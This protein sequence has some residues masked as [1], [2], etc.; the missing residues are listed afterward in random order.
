MPIR[1]AERAKVDDRGFQLHRHWSVQRD[2]TRVRVSREM[3]RHDSGSSGPG[4]YLQIYP[5]SLVNASRMMKIATAM[6]TAIDF[7][8]THLVGVASRD[9][10]QHEEL[11]AGVHVVRVNGSDRLGNIG[12]VLRL[13]FW[14][15]Q[16]YRHYRHSNVSVVAAHIV[17]VLPLCWLL[18]R[19]TGAALVYNAHELETETFTMRGLKQKVA[20]AI[21]SRLI[22]SCRLVSV[23]NSS[24]ADWY[25]AEYDIERPIVVGN[26]PVDRPTDVRMRERLGV[27]ASAMLYSHTGHLVGGRSIPLILASF[28]TS[29]HHVVFLGDG[30]YR[31][32]V[33]A[34]S[35]AHSNIHWLAPV[36][37]ELIVSHVREADV[38]LCLIECQLD[39][40]DRLS[41]PNKLL[42]SL[43]AGV[44]ALCSDLIEARK[45]LGLL[46]DDW[47][48]ANPSQELTS[49][50]ARITK[51]D[52]QKFR[53]S[54][55]GTTTWA[56]EV[57]P[58][59]R[60]Y[61]RLALAEAR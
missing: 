46:A 23:V 52:V 25:E 41:S 32:Q 54:W 34:A 33:V 30:P 19:K 47:L 6:H 21:E 57:A 58:L 56:D 8:E 1:D 51:S 26:V 59:A 53:D 3:P 10:Q 9:C 61:K 60:S 20:K 22:Q 18:S 44:P 29:D 11:S 15:P 12:R 13:L 42:E 50:L 49:A 39:L 36:D 4:L 43:A 5:S 31:E 28:A 16:V 35:I 40:S 24:I 2:R 38:G 7:S 14:Q 37:S 48:L 55:Q 27:P 45:L 17:W